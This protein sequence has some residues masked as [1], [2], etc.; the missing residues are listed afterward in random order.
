MAPDRLG[1]DGLGRTFN[2]AAQS[3]RS[4]SASR[5]Q[6]L[7]E[8]AQL[9]ARLDES[10]RTIARSKRLLD[11][12]QAEHGRLQGEL[13]LSQDELRLLTTTTPQL[14]WRSLDDGQWTSGSPQWESYTGQTDPQ[15]NGR[16]WLE[17]V[18]PDDRDQTMQAW[19]AAQARGELAVEHRLRRNADGAYRWF[20]TRAVPRQDG[21]EGTR[22]WF[23]I[24]AEI[25][26]L[27]AL[28]DRQGVL[29][30]ELQHRVRNTLAG[31][32]ALVRRSA[33]PDG[34][35]TDYVAHLDGRLNAF[36][37]VAS[38]VAR[39]PTAGVGLEGLVADELRASLAA[40][41]ERARIA[42][43]R[44]LLQPKAAEVLGLA[45]HELATNAIKYGALAAPFGQIRVSWQIAETDETSCLVL[46]WRERRLSHSI[47]PPTH[48]GFGLDTLE[49]TLPYE[50]GARTTLAFAP[51]GLV[52][53]MMIPLTDRNAAGDGAK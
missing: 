42:G 14:V 38:A 40:E 19:H 9:R 51:D 2:P 34:P 17:I 27:R 10:E 35:A 12:V 26:D 8:N 48:R 33:E 31:M 49:R 39:D 21:D 22:M 13:Q 16:G 23:G 25:H 5:A 37:R 43:P 45:L 18:H 11:E 24:S 52:C 47:V 3:D 6:L 30:A 50:L 7:A 4:P 20:Q 53:T 36:A 29:L 44:V 46:T 28:Q 15:A 32:R 1:Q 41:G